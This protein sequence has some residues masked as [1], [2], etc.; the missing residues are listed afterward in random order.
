MKGHRVFRSLSE[1]PLLVGVF[2]KVP[3]AYTP[4]FLAPSP[5]I[6]DRDVHFAIDHHDFL[7]W[8]RWPF[9]GQQL[10]FQG[11]VGAI[12]PNQKTGEIQRLPVCV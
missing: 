9:R 11:Q 8:Q 5:A 2:L 12:Q 7:A 3:A 10:P 1:I 4:Y 6:V